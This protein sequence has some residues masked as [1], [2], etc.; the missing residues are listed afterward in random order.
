MLSWAVM[1]FDEA[2]EIK[3][4]G[5]FSGPS[6][7]GVVFVGT[8]HLPVVGLWGTFDDPLKRGTL[9]DPLKKNSACLK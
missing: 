8:T 9:S 6:S 3:Q 1:G 5:L 2:I 4:C 7:W